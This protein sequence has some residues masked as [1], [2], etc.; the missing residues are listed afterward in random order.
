M[1]KPIVVLELPLKLSEHFNN[2]NEQAGQMLD[3]YHVITYLANILDPN[4][5]VF[6]AKDFNETEFD[7]LKESILKKMNSYG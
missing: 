5:K 2:I 1:P 3:D 7:K 6:Y 4:L